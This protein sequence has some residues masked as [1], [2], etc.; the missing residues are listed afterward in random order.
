VVNLSAE[1]AGHRRRWIRVRPEERVSRLLRGQ[2]SAMLR[3]RR[4]AQS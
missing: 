4:L 1:G 2:G 3:V